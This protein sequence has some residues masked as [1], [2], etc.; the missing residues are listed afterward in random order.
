M[1]SEIE[2]T[3]KFYL[4]PHFKD[5][6]ERL[7]VT[8][9]KCKDNNRS[10]RDL[11]LEINMTITFLVDKSGSMY[12]S[13][14]ELMAC[15]LTCD[16]ILR[17]INGLK[18]NLVEFSNRA[19]ITHRGTF[20]DDFR[21]IVSDICCKGMTNYSEAFNVTSEL[22]DVNDY[23]LVIFITDGYPTMGTFNNVSDAKIYSKKIKDFVAIGLGSD[24][25]PSILRALGDFVHIDNIKKCPE[26]LGAIF[27]SAL[28]SF[29]YNAMLN[30]IS[31]G[32]ALKWRSV[33]GTKFIGHIFE[34]KEKYQ[35][36][37]ISEDFLDKMSERKIELNYTKLDG[38][39]ASITCN[40]EITS[41]PIPDSILR[42]YYKSSLPRLIEFIAIERKFVKNRV[43]NWFDAGKE[44]REIVLE[45]LKG[46]VNM[47]EVEKMASYSNSQ[48]SYTDE[49]AMTNSQTKLAK[50]MHNNYD[51]Y[52]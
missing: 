31:E 46:N 34:G 40:V 29:G 23:H 43:L 32:D 19:E 37:S 28:N 13:K 14:E 7:L 22:I 4:S 3:S 51:I 47:I 39:N 16:D 8:Q 15:L 18:V 12:D 5:A 20:G 52:F 2:L 38:T 10:D 30:M 35:I 27:G 1:D 21:K 50:T 45:A 42:L 6:K 25:N 33:V 11:P 17:Q 41:D 24:I 49:V 36:A 48:V 9:I 26:V 44:E